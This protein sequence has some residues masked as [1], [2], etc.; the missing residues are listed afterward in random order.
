MVWL[1]ILDSNLL[2]SIV[3]LLVGLMAL[4]IYRRQ[5]VDEKRNAAQTIYNEVASAENRLKVL[6]E[7]FFAAE[8]PELESSLIMTSEN[9]SRY[10]YLFVKDMTAA[11][12]DTLDNFYNNCHAYDEAVTLNN[13]YFHAQTNRIAD[14]FST[15]FANVA[16]E[17]HKTNPKDKA[18]S[19]QMINDLYDFQ[20]ILIKNFVP[21]NYK[22]KKALQD[23]RSALVALETNVSLSSAGQIL[24]TLS[25]PKRFIP[26]ISARR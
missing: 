19:Q 2:Q 7:R 17:Y 13:S 1:Q 6:R 21:T 24:H 26:R 9:W 3:T 10:K 5:H 18:M 8:F 12:W 11:E 25:L 14:N 22:P 4:Y 20:D 15:Y 16:L 23:A